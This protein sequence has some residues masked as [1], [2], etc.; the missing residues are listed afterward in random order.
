M[1]Y[2]VRKKT[3]TLPDGTKKTVKFRGRTAREAEAK[4]NRAVYEYEQGRYLVNNNMTIARYVEQLQQ[5][6]DLSQDMRN[7]LQRH[8]VANIGTLRVQDV[9][10][11]HVDLCLAQVRGTSA[12]NIDKT[13]MALQL[14]FKSLLRDDLILRN[15]LDKLDKPK[16]HT[17]HRRALNSYEQQ[18]LRQTMTQ[19]MQ[20][21]REQDLIWCLIYACGLR[22]GEAR[23][24][25]WSNIYL[26]SPLAAWP[27]LR[28]TSAIKKDTQQIGAPKTSAGMRDVPIPEWV[29]PY[30][31]QLRSKATGTLLFPAPSGRIM[32]EQLYRNR[33]HSFLRRMDLAAGAKTYRNKIVQ[34]SMI[35]QDLTPYYLR[36]TYRT[37]LAEAGV[38]PLV[39]AYW[40]GHSDRGVNDIGYAH[41]TEQMIAEAVEILNAKDHSRDHSNALPQL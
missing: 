23:A 33:W 18:I 29:V 4:R 38:N 19:S 12:S 3:F 26:D 35:G 20:E 25:T 27:F 17:G 21:G 7:R 11:S 39:S 6:R 13:W 15:P 40:M 8:V 24:L 37:N 5:T 32:G 31:Q 1:D 28:I 9:R 2:V 16:G 34:H 30:L 36:H 41:L 10:A 14:L 22:P